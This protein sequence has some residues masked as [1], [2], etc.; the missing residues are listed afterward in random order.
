MFPEILRPLEEL[1]YKK[2]GMP[3]TEVRKALRKGGAAFAPIASPEVVG[4]ELG[5]AA[6]R[7]GKW[8]GRLWT[9]GRVGGPIAGLLAAGHML[10][11]KDPK[12]WKVKA[13]PLVA[14]AGVAPLLAE[15]AL[16]TRKGLKAVKK[17]APELSTKAFKGMKGALGRALGTYG[18]LMGMSAVLPVAAL[19]VSRTVTGKSPKQG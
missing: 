4:H 9:A 15:E 14:A 10:G 13:A 2:R 8:P 16:A 19:A 1:L 17:V 11:A 18:A 6:L 12:D 5:H 7:R 3:M